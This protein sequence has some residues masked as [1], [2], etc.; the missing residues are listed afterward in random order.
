[1]TRTLLV[2]TAM[3]FLTDRP[4]V[5]QTDLLVIQKKSAQVSFG[6]SRKTKINGEEG[7]FT[8]ALFALERARESTKRNQKKN[9][10]KVRP[11][12]NA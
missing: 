5:K 8:R 11:P 12:R 9:N 10:Q 2:K 4:V 7:R 1:M 3:D 6:L